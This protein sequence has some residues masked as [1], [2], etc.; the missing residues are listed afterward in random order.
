MLNFSVEVRAEEIASYLASHFL[1]EYFRNMSLRQIVLDPDSLNWNGSQPLRVTYSVPGR[2]EDFELFPQEHAFQIIRSIYPCFQSE[3]VQFIPNS[4][5]WLWDNEKITIFFMLKEQETE[6][7]GEVFLSDEAYL[8]FSRRE[9][10][11]SF[12]V[13]QEYLEAQLGGLGVD[14]KDD[15]SPIYWDDSCGGMVYRNG[16]AKVQWI[17]SAENSLK[18]VFHFVGLD[19][20]FIQMK[21]YVKPRI[22]IGTIS[23]SVFSEKGLTIP[24]RVWDTCDDINGI[25]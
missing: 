18:D 23:S 19:T 15:D 20:A 14:L 25:T 2:I 13:I 12:E 7:S 8:S 17:L 6:P 24:L 1:P 3:K 10:F 11:L 5:M 9:A 16:N 22:E 21:E 4:S